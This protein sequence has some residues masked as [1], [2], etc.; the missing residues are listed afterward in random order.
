MAWE[1]HVGVKSV[2]VRVD[3]GPW[4]KATLADS[5]SAD[6]WRQWV[7]RWPATTGSHKIEVRATDASG[8]TQRQTHQPPAPNGS[9]GWHSIMVSVT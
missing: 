6:T 1:Q 8:S 4:S 5:I 2:E 7:Y 3:N 9:E